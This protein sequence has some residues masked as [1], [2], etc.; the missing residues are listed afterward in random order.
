MN[1]ILLLGLIVS[2]GC[3]D[4]V[5]GFKNGHCYTQTSYQRFG[6]LKTTQGSIQFNR[7]DEYASEVRELYGHPSSMGYYAERRLFTEIACPKL[8]VDRDDKKKYTS[9]G[10]LEELKSYGVNTD[11]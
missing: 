6:Q 8:T 7:Y 4:N 10:L 3:F 1:K 9:I 5:R 2:T 11:E